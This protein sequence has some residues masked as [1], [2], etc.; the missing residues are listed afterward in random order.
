MEAEA[1]KAEE[2]P[3]TVVEVAAGVE[4]DHPYHCESRARLF[5][6]QRQGER[7]TKN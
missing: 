2:R 5:L 4:A 7:K 1:L 3:V 6:P